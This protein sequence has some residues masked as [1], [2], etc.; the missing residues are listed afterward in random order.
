MDAVL[1]RRV[2]EKIKDVYPAI[3]NKDIVVL[4]GSRAKGSSLPKSDVDIWIF[5]KRIDYFRKI[6]LDK[7]L[8]KEGEDPGFEE[9]VVKDILLEVKFSDLNIPKFESIFYHDILNAK[10]LTSIKSFKLFQ[11]KL[12]K[13]F[14]KNYDNLLFKTYIHFFKELKNL[15]G[16]TKREDKLS[17]INLNM[18]K[19][20]VVQAL[21]R[22]FIVINKQPY[23]FDKFLSH[24]ASELKHWGKI[25]HFINKLNNVTSLEEFKIIKSE[26]RDFIDSG[27]PKR[28]Y[29]GAWWKYLKFKGF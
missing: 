26:L 16:I 5:T 20:L 1:K 28:P 10:P 29:V 2:F 15:E 8:R 17:R 6:S 14:F 13:E 7:G 19:G 23:T 21:L 9:N 27:M 24:Q 3:N 22:L 4:F 25:N 18:K 12:R 11:S